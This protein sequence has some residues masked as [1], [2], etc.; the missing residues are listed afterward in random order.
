MISSVVRSGRALKI[1]SST[2]RS[3]IATEARLLLQDEAAYARMARRENPF[4][5]GKAAGR[6]VEALRRAPRP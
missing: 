3:A 1:V 6:I 5:D 2:A 4:G